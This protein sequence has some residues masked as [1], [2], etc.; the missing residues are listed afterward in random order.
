MYLASCPFNVLFKSMDIILNN[1][2]NKEYANN[3]INKRKFH[4][5]H[6][7]YNI[8]EYKNFHTRPSWASQCMQQHIYHTPAHQLPS[9]HHYISQTNIHGSKQK[10]TNYSTIYYLCYTSNAPIT[11]AK[12]IKQHTDSYL[13]IH[14]RIK[15]TLSV[16]TALLAIS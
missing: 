13:L 10:A 12:T 4:Y 8:A 1:I 14:K 7:T 15:I 6:N 16:I 11:S 5:N 3:I 9:Y 2:N